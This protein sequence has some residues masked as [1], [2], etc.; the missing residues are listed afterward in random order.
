MHV[1]VQKKIRMIELDIHLPSSFFPYISDGSF[2]ISA[3]LYLYF[4]Y[5]ENLKNSWLLKVHFVLSKY[6]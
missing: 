5:G 4:L 3:F 6:I 1:Q 2:Q